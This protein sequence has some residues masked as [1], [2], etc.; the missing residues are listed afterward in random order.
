MQKLFLFLLIPVLGLLAHP[1]FAQSSQEIRAQVNSITVD[2][3]VD[4][5]RHVIFSASDVTGKTYI[6]DSGDSYL[7]GIKYNLRP[8]QDVLL[9]QVD[10]GDGSAPSVFLIDVV[11]VSALIWIILLFALLTIVIGCTRGGFALLGLGVTLLILFGFILPQILAGHSP[12]LITILGSIAILAVNMHLTHGCN[13]RTWFGFLSTIVGLLFVW[14]FAEAFVWFAQLSGL[15]SEEVSLLFLTTDQIALPTGL[16]LAG[17]ILGAT[18]VLDDIAVTQTETVEEL[19]Q[20]DPTLSQ[21]ELFFKAMNI[22]RHHIASVVNTLVL[23][24]AGVALPIFLLFYLRE[25]MSTWRFINE[26][27]VAEEMIR[28]LAG[29]MALILLVPISTWMATLVHKNSPH[30]HSR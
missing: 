2:E 6:V 1:V 12:V 20:T 10:I 9:Q 3:T 11:R 7:Q 23:A 14:G 18:G 25:D 22:G 19:K 15:A 30:K 5:V 28:T 16:L 21:K 26:E 24:Y 17:I 13:K 8:G 27:L 4:G 29:T